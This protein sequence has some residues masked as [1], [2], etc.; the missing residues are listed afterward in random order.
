MSLND[1]EIIR[2]LGKGVFGVVYLATRKVDN[3]IYA[4][5]QVKFTDLKQKEISNSLN[6]IRI[7]ASIS[8][9]N[10]IGYKESFYDLPANT[11]NLVL[12][13]ADDGDLQSQITHH[14]QHK[15]YFPECTIWSFFIQMIS[16]L[17]VLHKHSIM[18]RDLKSANIFLTKHG[19]CKLG[20]LNVSKVVKEGLLHTQTGTPYYASPEVWMDKP[21][22]YK[23]DIWSIGCILYEMCALTLPFKGKTFENVYKNVLKGVYNPIPGHYSK[24]LSQVIFGL[25]QV[26]PN[27]RPS[28]Q[29]ILNHVVIKQMGEM[30][31]GEDVKRGLRPYFNKDGSSGDDNGCVSGKND[32]LMKTLVVTSEKE[33]ERVLPKNKNYNS[34]SKRLYQIGNTGESKKNKIKRNNEVMRLECKQKESNNNNNNSNNKGEVISSIL[35]QHNNVINNNKGMIMNNNTNNVNDNNSINVS[36]QNN[37]N[38]NSNSYSANKSKYNNNNNNNTLSEKKRQ[39]GD[40]SSKLTSKILHNNI[41]NNEHQ[42]L[43]HHPQLTSLSKNHSVAAIVLQP[44]NNNQHTQINNTNTN[45][46]DT[47]NTT[48]KSTKQTTKLISRPKS[49]KPSRSKTP[50]KEKQ[51][52]INKTTTQHNITNNNNNISNIIHSKKNPFNTNNNIN[53]NSIQPKLNHKQFEALHSPIKSNN[54]RNNEFIITNQ[55]KNTSNTNSEG[56]LIYSHNHNQNQR[57]QSCCYRNKEGDD[58]DPSKKMLMNPIRVIEN[59]NL[60]KVYKINKHPNYKFSGSNI[61]N[62]IVQ[63]VGNEKPNVSYNNVYRKIKT[64]NNEDD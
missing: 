17:D 22:N 35:K 20:D 31:I 43:S 4:I 55:N 21:Y 64:L 15:T 9:Q 13:Y 45:Q 14:K 30:Y 61:A 54:K 3:N 48:Q 5:K 49:T 11:L 62:K 8:H 24:E 39:Y 1:F 6:E 32:E 25:L 27:N 47:A 37:Y 18:H 36:I 44:I 53:S 52:Q 58:V 50:H 51:R 12:E 10:I 41:T 63:S 56:V 26:N 46:L 38:C 34:D 57:P 2:E 29:E 19:L 40:I 42:H 59:K 23:S 7:L 60:K 28:C 33:I 16:G